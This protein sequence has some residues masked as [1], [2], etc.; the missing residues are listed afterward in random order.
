MSYL[1]N[2][3]VVCF[4]DQ[5]SSLRI[6]QLIYQSFQYVLLLIQS[7]VS[8]FMRSPR[9]KIALEMI[10]YKSFLYFSLTTEK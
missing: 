3:S 8:N 10:N 4:S 5:Y 2:N 9:Q 7:L 6:E 1:R